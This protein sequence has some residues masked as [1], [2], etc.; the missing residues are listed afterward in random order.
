[1]KEFTFSKVPSLKLKTQK[2]ISFKT[3]FIHWYFPRILKKFFATLIYKN[4][5]DEHCGCFWKFTP[6][7]WPSLTN[8]NLTVHYLAGFSIRDNLKRYLHNK[9]GEITVKPAYSG[10]RRLL[11]K[12]SAITRCLLYRVL[13]F[14][15]KRRQHKLRWRIFIL[16]S[17]E[18][19]FTTPI[20]TLIENTFT[21]FKYFVL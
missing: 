7:G 9:H 20:P 4:T 16:R 5:L 18:T 11:K 2:Q 10:H 13:H 8:D 15:G 3:S 12:V 14:L 6:T 19:P 1:M 21:T 17:K